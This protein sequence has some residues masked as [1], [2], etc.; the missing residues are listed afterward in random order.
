M[1]GG[2]QLLRRDAALGL[3]RQGHGDE[4]RS[5]AVLPGE[6]GLKDHLGRI[7]GL[8]CDPGTA[9]ASVTD[10]PAQAQVVGQLFR[11]GDNL[12]HLAVDE[13]V[14]SGTA[15]IFQPAGHGEHLPVVVD[16]VF[17]R[18]QGASLVLGLHYH[19]GRSQAGDDAVA[20]HKVERH[21]GGVQGIV[22]QQGA[23]GTADYVHGQPLV[24]EGIH[25]VYT[26]SHY[27][28]GGKAALQRRPVRYPVGPQ[29]QSAHNAGLH[30]CL[31]EAFNQ[32]LTPGLPV[33]T[34][35][36]CAHK[37]H[38]R[39]KSEDFR[40][41]GSPVQI[42]AEG[43]FRA[44]AKR[45]RIVRIQQGE[46]AEA[47]ALDL[48]QFPGSPLQLGGYQLGKQLRMPGRFRAG[49]VEKGQGVVGL[50]QQLQ[51]QGGVVAKNFV[52]GTKG[53]KFVV[54]SHGR[55]IGAEKEKQHNR[56]KNCVVLGGIL[57]VS[58]DFYTIKRASP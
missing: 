13:R 2:H 31:R 3:D 35:V 30:P 26:G 10:R 49:S 5:G 24:L 6:K 29:R 46:E 16:G 28:Y 4:G 9:R 23:S 44:L 40:R 42:Q 14:A 48:L 34:Q 12:G 55:K 33:G 32:F 37:A 47:S 51:P 8:G 11:V 56:K 1:Q 53:H 25:F 57:C 41:G 21:R 15:D 54:R 45:L 17:G 22:C 19:H 20:S 18:H 39:P 52:Q 43:R 50:L 58:Y 27:S 7:T 38:H 36:P